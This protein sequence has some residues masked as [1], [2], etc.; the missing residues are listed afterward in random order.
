MKTHL[1]HLTLS[2][3]ITLLFSCNGTDKKQENQ[4]NPTVLNKEKVTASQTALDETNNTKTIVIGN[5]E[6]APTDYPEKMRWFL[7]QQACTKL[8]DGWRLPTIEELRIMYDNREKIGGFD[9]WGNYWS[10]SVNEETPTFVEVFSFHD[11]KHYNVSKTDY[12]YS[13]RAVRSK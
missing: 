7:A 11:G 2:I 6:I 13:F 8:G 10:T 5:L 12:N 9:D 3:G 1:T 4:A